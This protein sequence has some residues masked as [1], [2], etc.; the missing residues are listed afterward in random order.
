[1]EQSYFK[2]KCWL[3]SQL[4]TALRGLVPLTQSFG[5][6]APN[7]TF[8]LERLAAVLFPISGWFGVFSGVG[9]VKTSKV[10]YT[11]YLLVE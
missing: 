9:S 4:A 3:R 5:S 7:W 8:A 11:G 2:M 1:M 6:V 10:C